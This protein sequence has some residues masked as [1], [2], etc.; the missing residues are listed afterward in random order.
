MIRFSS[1]FIAEEQLQVEEEE[2]PGE[3]EFPDDYE[4]FEFEEN[5]NKK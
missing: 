1:L 5:R 2:F 4:D 3:L